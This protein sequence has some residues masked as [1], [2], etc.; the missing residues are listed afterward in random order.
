MKFVYLIIAIISTAIFASAQQAQPLTE[1]AGTAIDQ[2]GASIPSVRI[3]LSNIKG[4]KYEVMTSDDG[5]FRLKVPAGTYLVE[6]EYIPNKVWEPFRIEKYEVAANKRMTLDICLR[7]DQEF[8][9]THAT[10]VTSEKRS[11]HRKTRASL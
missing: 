7:V 4:T 5:S 11:S 3:V 10:P 9:K 1:L 8:I 6:A 2:A